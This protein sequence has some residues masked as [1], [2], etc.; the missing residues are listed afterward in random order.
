MTRLRLEVAFVLGIPLIAA[1]IAIRS[2]APPSSPCA[3]DNTDGDVSTVCI[4]EIP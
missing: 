3:A 1:L 2:L 4:E